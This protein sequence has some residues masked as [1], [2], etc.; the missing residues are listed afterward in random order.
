MPLARAVDAAKAE[1]PKTANVKK[2]LGKLTCADFVG[3]DVDDVIKPL[4]VIAAVTYTKARPKMQLSKLWILT[5][6]FQ[7]WEECQKTPKESFWAKLKS[8]LKL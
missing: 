4:Y 3:V 8:K 5:H 6:S 1:T 7:F 2:P